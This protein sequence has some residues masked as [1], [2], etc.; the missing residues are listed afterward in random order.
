MASFTNH[1]TARKHEC[2][3]FLTS[4]SRIKQIQQFKTS[5]MW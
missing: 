3:N 1:K 2:L 4:L 5:S